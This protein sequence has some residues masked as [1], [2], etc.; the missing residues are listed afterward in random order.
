M[1][2]F[3]ALVTQPG[4]DP[5]RTRY[6]L[7]TGPTIRYAPSATFLAQLLR[8]NASRPAVARASL[9]TVS[10][11]AYGPALAQTASAGAL[12]RL[13]GTSLESRAVRDALEGV[14]DVVALEGQAAR[15]PAVRREIR[16]K[17]Y[18][19]I[20]THGLVDEGEADL[21]AALALTPPAG[22]APRGD[23]DGFLQ[24]FEIYD[25]ALDSDLAVLS[26]CSS[27]AGRVVTGEGVFALS[28]G[29]L[30][31]GARR[32]VAS[33]WAVDDASTAELV[34]GLFH[35]VAA[36]ETSGERLDAASAL[37]DAKLR[38]RRDRRW[39]E[40]FFWAPFVLTGID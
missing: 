32:V 30:V 16:G 24:L 31:A 9:L 2:P 35:R 4:S 7:D 12:E 25:L 39:A 18:L 29:F 21:F 19:H 3:E 6:W 8:R 10:D 40:P 34:S 37:R 27:N 36:A 22:Q 13:P 17:R 26:T 1:L 14:A 23:D 20:A 15:E 33:Q 38:L 11:P 28:R 5:G